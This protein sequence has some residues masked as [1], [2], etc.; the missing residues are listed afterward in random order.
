VALR[1]QRWASDRQVADSAKRPA[2]LR[3][4]LRQVVHIR[5]RVR[6]TV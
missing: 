6:Q 2:L 3:N 5:V 4:N 1:A